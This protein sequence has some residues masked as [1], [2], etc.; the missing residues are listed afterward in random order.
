MNF[1]SKSFWHPYILLIP[2][3]MILI[4]L[5]LRGIITGIA[6]SLGYFPMVGLKDL[7]LKYY[8][9]IWFSSEFIDALGFSL[10]ISFVS[11]LIAVVIG[12][13]LAYQLVKLPKKHKII[14]LLYKLPIVVPHIIAS[15]LVFLFFTQSGILSRILFHIGLIEEIQQFPHLIFD[16]GGIGIILVYLW[17]FTPFIALVSFTILKHINNSYTEV[18]E[19]LGA[20]PWQIFWNVY[21]PLALPSIASSFII[22][23]AF[24]FGAFEIPYLLGPTY[25]RT[26]PVLAYQKYISSNLL[27]RPYAM[28]IAV[29]L[30]IICF[31]LIIMYVK[32]LN[33]VFK[34]D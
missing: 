32:L 18:A 33:Y 16:D 8:Y 25:P 9:E 13:F 34:Y 21:F 17:K 20:N 1:K 6:Q 29:T 10:Y 4:G 14:R 26:L 7:T 27:E 2:A 5:F 28:V 31:I 30:S 19:N 11:S 22:I 12:V 15:L 23:F 24:S 3:L